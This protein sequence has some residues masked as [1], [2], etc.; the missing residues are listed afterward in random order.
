LF[1]FEVSI[2]KHGVSVALSGWVN[3]VAAAMHALYVELL[4]CR[5]TRFGSSRTRFRRYPGNFLS[6]FACSVDA[7]VTT[8]CD[9]TI[10]I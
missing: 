3:N 6:I 5:M 7:Q 9:Q 1:L 2:C 8:E 10:A 4:T